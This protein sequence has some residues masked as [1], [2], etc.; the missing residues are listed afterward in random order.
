[1]PTPVA[2]RHDPQNNKKARHELLVGGPFCF[3]VKKER[4]SAISA[5]RHSAYQPVIRKKT[6]VE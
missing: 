1:M 3:E 5:V 4:N 6:N 2:N